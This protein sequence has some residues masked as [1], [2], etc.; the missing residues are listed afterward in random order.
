MTSSIFTPGDFSFI[1][2]YMT[3][4]AIEDGYKA[5]TISE[6]WAWLSGFNPNPQESFMLCTAPELTEIQAK[7]TVDHSGAS[8]AITMRHLAYIAKHGWD[9]YVNHVRAN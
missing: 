8:F 5:L 2:D 9:A 3:R 6:Q 1:S 4:M 7:M